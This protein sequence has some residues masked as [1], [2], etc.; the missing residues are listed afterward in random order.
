MSQAFNG[1]G[2][3]RTTTIINLFA[4]WLFQ[5]PLAYVMAVPLGLGPEGV[6]ISVAISIG[7]LAGAFILVFR[8]G[9]WKTVS[10]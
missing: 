3:T 4:Y 10:I 9:R 7:V 6:F 8:K 1:A 2:D 5:L